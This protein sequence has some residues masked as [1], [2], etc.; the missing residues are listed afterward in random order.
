MRA[1]RWL[2]LAVI[3]AGV[4]YAVT[5][6]SGVLNLSLPELEARYKLPESQ[7]TELDGVRVHYVD[8]GQ[9]PV[10]V[11][12]HASFNNLHSW[13]DLAARLKDRYRVIR[14]DQLTNGLT[15]PDPKKDYSLQHN[16]RLL[17][18]LLVKLGVTEIFLLGTSSGGTTAFRYAATHPGQVKRLILVNSAGMPRTAT[19][20]PNRPRGTLVQ[21]WVRS[22]YKSKGYWQE[23]LKRQFGGGSTPPDDLVQRV[24]DMNRRDSLRAEGA[25]MMQQFKTGDPQAVLG[26]IKV[27]TLVM[28]G[29]GNITVAHLEGDVFQHWLVQAPTILKKYDKVGHYFYLEMPEQ[30]ASDVAAFLGG[31]WDG[32]LI[33]VSQSR[34]L[35]SE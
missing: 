1:L 17:E 18:A 10:V 26:Q 2:I 21:Q 31:Q 29:K 4:A 15:G 30:F 12:L 19:T 6:T 23:N 32:E 33:R 7:F 13:N 24:Y 34:G 28:W 22:Y 14:F 3:G 35:Q 8:Q 11:L 9:G 27:P 5:L 25:A 20:D 16:E